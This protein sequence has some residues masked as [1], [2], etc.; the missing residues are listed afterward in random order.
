MTAFGL[1]LVEE[2]TGASC[3]RLDLDGYLHLLAADMHTSPRDDGYRSAPLTAAHPCSYER[4][5][6]VRFEPPFTYIYGL[7]FWAPNLMLPSGWQISWGTSEEYRQPTRAP[8]SV[9]VQDVPTSEPDAVNFAV[10]PL[11]GEDGIAYSPWA[12]LQARLV[13]DVPAGPA[14]VEH[15][16]ELDVPVLIVYHLDWSEG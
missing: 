11:P 14:I 5:F 13:G 16:P 3:D 12:V 1:A 4:W 10:R 8:S 2:A 6:R 7:R 15:G 9:A